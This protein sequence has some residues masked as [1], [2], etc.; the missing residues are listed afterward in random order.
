MDDDVVGGANGGSLL[1]SVMV[2]PGPAAE[3]VVSRLVTDFTCA[4]AGAGET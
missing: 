1:Q 2:N 4:A 3:A